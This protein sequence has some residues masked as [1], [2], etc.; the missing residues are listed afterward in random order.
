MLDSEICGAW[1]AHIVQQIQQSS[2]ARITFV[3][4]NT[5]AAP[6][7]P[8]LG[9]RLRDHWKQTL[10]H[11]YERWDY[12]RNR[13]KRH[14]ARALVD[15]ASLLTDI[16]ALQVQPLRKGF[17]D[18]FSVADLAIIRRQ[19]LDVTFRFGFRI[20]RGD[21]LSTARYGI[22]SFH[23]DDNR[24]YRGGPPLFW[25][26][27]EGNPVSGAILQILTDSLDGGRVLYRG[28]SATDQ[29][30]LYRNRNPVYWRTAAA[31]LRTLE[32][33]D[34]SG[35]AALQI[36]PEGATYDRVIFRTPNTP[37]MASFLVRMIS[38]TLRARVKG[39][40]RGTQP[41]WFLALRPRSGSEPFSTTAGYRLF[42]P[43]ADR[44]YADPFLVERDGRTYLFFET[45]LYAEGQA[46]I[47][48]A[49]LSA[50]GD[51]G[52]TFEVL[53]RPYHLSYPFVFEHSGEMYMIP[54][55][56][57]NHTIELYRANEFPRGWQQVAT[58]LSDIYAVDATLL[59]HAGKLWIFAGL[60]DGRYSNSDELGIFFAD[61]LLG[62]WTPHPANPVLS[63]VR[64]A[65][66]AG[67]F[68]VDNG[69][70]IR[71]SQDCSKA[72]GYALNFS[73]VA[74]LTETV[75]REHPVAHITPDWHRNNL[76]TH[77][78]NRSPHFEVIDGNIA[79]RVRTS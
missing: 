63:D 37:Q 60:S 47:E 10:F 56:K 72:Y 59:E 52:P 50:T 13:V 70:L 1:V 40:L 67:A 15:L 48:C 32:R 49:E 17:T 29:T 16:P 35:P 4:R 51:P 9:R 18:R 19:D 76:G 25:E 62:P 61:H 36:L 45:F 66:P 8:P 73:E 79:A 58:L 20:I 21:I 23:H 30:S 55:S 42:S 54:E 78:Y 46:I 3:I 44:F 74:Q 75:Y 69:V 28:L 27:F 31:A 6:H 77:T 41:Q 68:F 71:P 34:A 65:R 39:R 11:R 14:D 57:Q 2:F 26:I 24:H 53:R 64:L 22:W 12:E 7:R 33:L 38:R 43:P 5:P